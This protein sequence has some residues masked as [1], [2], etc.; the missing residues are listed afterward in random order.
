MLAGNAAAHNDLGQCY[1]LGDGVPKD[2]GK[3]ID[4]WSKGAEL[5]DAGSQFNLGVCYMNGEHVTKDTTKARH[6][7]EQAAEQGH[8]GAIRALHHMEQREAQ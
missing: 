4:L 2:W 3:A 1:F 8:V 7:F 5:G 6:C